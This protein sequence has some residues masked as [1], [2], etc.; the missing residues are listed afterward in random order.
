GED[1]PRV[2]ALYQNTPNPFGDV[3][4]IRYA[5]PRKGEV[6]LEVYNVLGQKISVLESGVKETGFYDVK[7]DGR[8]SRGM[9]VSGGVYFVRFSS[10]DFHSI[11][12]IVKLR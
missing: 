5:I 10:G 4:R 9:R 1:I 8:D 2:Y 3:T 6:S 7:W 12:K 11:K